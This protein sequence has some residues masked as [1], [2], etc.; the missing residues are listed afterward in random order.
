M[1]LID[2]QNEHPIGPLST[3]RMNRS[4]LA[5]L[6]RRFGKVGRAL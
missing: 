4:G 5:V 1:M 3:Q 6:K 2:A